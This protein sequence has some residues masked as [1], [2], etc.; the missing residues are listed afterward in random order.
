M[1]AFISSRR[2][3]LRPRAM[4]MCAALFA[5]Q[6]LSACSSTGQANHAMNS[7][8]VMAWRLF[9]EPQALPPV[10]V[11]QDIEDDGIAAQTPPPKSIRN[12]KDDPTQPW[13]PNY[14]RISPGII[15]ASVPEGA[16]TAQS[17]KLL[18]QA[19]VASQ[20]TE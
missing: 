2:P 13:S 20:E 17:G 1:F 18:E 3:V 5:A 9:D 6:S 4:I 8:A 14:G 19:Q 12:Q 16:A 15:A 7:P 10:K 11:K